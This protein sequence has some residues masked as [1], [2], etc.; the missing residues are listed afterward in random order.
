MEESRCP[1]SLLSQETM[2]FPFPVYDAMRAESPVYRDAVTGF[3]VVT[4]YEDV[5]QIAADPQTFSNKTGLLGQR[6][7]LAKEE[8]SKLYQEHGFPPIDTLVTNDPPDHRRYRSLVDKVFSARRVKD[9]EPAI[10][11]AIDELIDGFPTE[12]FDFG[13]RFAT[14]LPVR[15]IAEQ[16]GVPRE[17]SVDFKRWSDALINSANQGLSYEQEID[18]AKGIVEMQAFFRD[19]VAKARA[20]PSGS[21][22]SAL[23]N[24]ENDFG[25]EMSVAEVVS[26]LQQVLVAGNE[27]TTNAT[28]SGLYRLTQDPQLQARLRTAPDLIP[29]FVEEVLRLDSP[30]QGLFRRATRDTDIGGIPVP[31]GAILNIRWGAANRDPSQWEHATELDLDRS[32]IPHVAFGY[33]IHFCIGNQLARSEMRLA[34]QRLL[35]GSSS[36]T[37]ADGP[38]AVTRLPHFIAYGVRR[39]MID[40]VPG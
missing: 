5:K 8:V 6:A 22:L 33:G 31:E 29:T 3:L 12:S 20:N 11:A 9:A 32:R 30:L 25:E 28:A 7:S 39:L 40:F 26:L 36:I 18:C 34:F 14:A 37:L 27:T 15:I 4:R 21:L 23:A 1:L 16:L 19:E 2:A 13:E 38:E 17:R 35:A 24:T 10:Q